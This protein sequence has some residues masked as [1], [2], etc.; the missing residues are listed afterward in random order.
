[1]VERLDRSVNIDALISRNEI[2]LYVV[3]PDCHTLQRGLVSRRQSGLLFD[4]T[5]CY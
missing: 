3:L 1:M 5:C 2:M 4:S